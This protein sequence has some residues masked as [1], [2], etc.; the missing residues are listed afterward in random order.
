M[1]REKLQEI[2]L[3]L[4]NK[5]AEQYKNDY[6]LK[7][8]CYWRIAN[9]NAVGKK[10]T[11]VIDKPFYKKC[12]RDN[13][14]ESVNIMMRMQDKPNYILHYNEISLSMRNKHKWKKDA[15]NERAMNKLINRQI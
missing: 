15:Y 4:G 10:W 11:E 14:Q 1:T 7:N 9:D 3:T 13:L 5:L 8:H 2:Y 12:S 6:R